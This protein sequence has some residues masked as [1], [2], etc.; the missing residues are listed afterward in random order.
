MEKFIKIN[1]DMEYDEIEDNIPDSISKEIYK[2]V[3]SYKNNLYDCLYMCES[4]IEQLMAIELFDIEQKL[5][6][7]SSN[8][9]IL[10][11]ANQEQIITKKGKYRVDFLLEIA[12]KIN[13]KYMELLK[14]V[15]ECDGHKF[16]NVTKEQVKKDNEENRELFTDGYYVLRFSGSEI[17]NDLQ[18]CGKDIIKFIMSRYNQLVK[19][20][21][22]GR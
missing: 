8:V 6:S 3:E 15:I 1:Y 2:R 10:G 5:S 21:Q 7:I 9:E 19:E 11:I 17:F 4:P 20:T 16:H 18:G 13:N 14:I 22:N 12:L